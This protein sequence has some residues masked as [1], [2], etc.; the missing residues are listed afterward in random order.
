VGFLSELRSSVCERRLERA[1]LKPAPLPVKT[2]QF[3]QFSGHL[4]RHTIESLSLT[5]SVQGALGVGLRPLACR[6]CGF[7]SRPDI[8]C[9]CCLCCQVEIS[10]TSRS[11]LQRSPTGCG[12]S[13][14]VIYKP[15]E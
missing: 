8:S 3:T 11:V 13:F 6:D 2:A 14:S 10:A 4:W 12:V 1:I 7:E 5:E 9:Q 15:Q